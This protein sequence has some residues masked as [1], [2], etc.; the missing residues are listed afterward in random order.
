MQLSHLLE[1]VGGTNQSIR[2]SAEDV[3][4]TLAA[5]WPPPGGDCDHP[6]TQ[7]SPPPTYVK[8]SDIRNIIAFLL[9]TKCLGSF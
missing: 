5:S 3:I 4:A 7:T 9:Q 2:S 6:P 1:G 8:F